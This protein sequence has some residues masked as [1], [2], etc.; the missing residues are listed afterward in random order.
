MSVV[1]L[2][3][4][5]LAPVSY[6]VLLAR[7]GKVVIEQ[8]ENYQK[9]SYRNR[10][11]IAAANGPMVLSIPVK[12]TLPGKKDKDQGPQAKTYPLAFGSD[13]S[14]FFFCIAHIFYD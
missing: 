11:L 10:C 5:Y 8:H 13:E 3:T 14:T 9:Q 7:A 2:S 12:K 1:L 4:A 6:Y